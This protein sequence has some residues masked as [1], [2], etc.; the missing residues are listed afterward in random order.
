[1]YRV[2]FGSLPFVHKGE[3]TGFF[4]TQGSGEQKTSLSEKAFDI[5]GEFT[6]HYPEKVD[7]KKLGLSVT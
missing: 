1:M 3:K 7:L 4:P 2:A 6:S 5:I